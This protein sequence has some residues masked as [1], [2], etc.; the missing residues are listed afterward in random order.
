MIGS[1][2]SCSVKILFQK[3][4]HCWVSRLVLKLTRLEWI[5]KS[6]VFVQRRS[7]RATKAQ[8]FSGLGTRRR[9]AGCGEL[10]TTP[11]TPHRRSDRAARWAKLLLQES[12]SQRAS[13]PEME[14]WGWSISCLAADA[15]KWLKA[16]LCSRWCRLTPQMCAC[17]CHACLRSSWRPR[18]TWWRAGWQVST[19]QKKQHV[20]L[21]QKLSLQGHFQDLTLWGKQ[22]SVLDTWTNLQHD[23]Q[24]KPGNDEALIL[25]TK[26]F[27]PPP[28]VCL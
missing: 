23:F 25:W 16:V 27:K 9:G 3:S 1:L 6:C 13:T 19:G 24:S 14:T 22:D 7:L 15:G 5:M 10:A 18:R 21:I 11:G 20:W 17:L 4:K 12:C 28:F 26:Q 8:T 2:K